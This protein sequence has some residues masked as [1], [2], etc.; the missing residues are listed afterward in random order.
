[1]NSDINCPNMPV[2]DP[3]QQPP[4]GLLQHAMQNA[5]INTTD[6]DEHAVEDESDDVK[7]EPGEEMILLEM[8]ND[9]ANDET[10][11]DGTCGQVIN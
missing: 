3:G 11:S 1:M 9:M 8:P 10:G 7:W 4:T 5:R 6:V 2:A